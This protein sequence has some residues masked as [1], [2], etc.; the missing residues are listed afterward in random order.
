MNQ[1]QNM[2]CHCPSLTRYLK[3]NGAGCFGE[4]VESKGGGGGFKGYVCL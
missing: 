1:N 4:G 3:W 2:C